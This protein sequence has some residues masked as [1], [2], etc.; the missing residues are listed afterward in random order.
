ML[1]ALP[2]SSV[3]PAVVVIAS[4]ALEQKEILNTSRLL[5]LTSHMLARAFPA[6]FHSI[7][8]LVS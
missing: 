6:S 2:V 8:R 1:S 7:A 3:A 4:E 5:P